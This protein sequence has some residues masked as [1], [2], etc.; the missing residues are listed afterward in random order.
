MAIIG[1][2]NR[3]PAPVKA[4][5]LQ[6][7]TRHQISVLEAAGGKCVYGLGVFDRNAQKRRKCGTRADAVK[8]L[9]YTKYDGRQYS[10]K[11]IRSVR[12]MD[13]IQ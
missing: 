10:V 11:L 3:T 4:Q 2:S 6:D 12:V 9:Y 7:C 1:Q 5:G 13:S 8:P